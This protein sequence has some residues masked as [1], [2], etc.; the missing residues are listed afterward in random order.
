MM[1]RLVARA[2][3]LARARQRAKVQVVADRLKSLLGE[4]VVEVE[5]ARVL[6][7]GRGIVRR[8]LI[9]PSLRL[10]AGRLK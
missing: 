8:W 3:A 9:D 7:R 10:L 5:E 2:E 1:E 4:A 6:V